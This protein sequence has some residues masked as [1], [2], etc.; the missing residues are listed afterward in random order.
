MRIESQPLNST[1]LDYL[2]RQL[3]RVNPDLLRLLGV[4]ARDPLIDGFDH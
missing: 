2:D 1:P 4:F 3:D